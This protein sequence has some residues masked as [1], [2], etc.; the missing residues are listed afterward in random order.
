MIAEF[1]KY[2]SWLGLQPVQ[3]VLLHSSF[4]KIR[5]AFP[6]ISIEKL[7]EAMQEIITPN[8]S[9]IMPAFTYCFEKSTGDHEIFDQ[10]NSP[11]KVGAVSE[12]FRNMPGVV[13]TAS[14]T[15]SFSLWGKVTEAIDANNSPES[16]L[17]EGSVLDWLA[18]NSS[19][20]ILLLGVNFS[21]MS[22]CHYLEIKAPAPWADYSPWDYM[23]VKK[24]G[25]SKK[26]RQPLREIPGCAKAFVNFEAELIRRGLIRPFKQAELSSCF[27]PVKLILNEGLEYF[28]KHPHLLLCPPG[29]CPACDARHSFTTDSIRLGGWNQLGL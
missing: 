19:S 28:R 14:P 13:R 27:F 25:V 17:G 15:H 20:F 21:A 23:H 7:I 5:S 22:F 29:S 8:G 2:L 16:P 1:S 12:A 9:L 18:K 24:V 11:G 4:R 6:G 3:H 10:Q 26:G